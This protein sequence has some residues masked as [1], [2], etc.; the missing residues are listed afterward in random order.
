MN[1][2]IK[3]LFENINGGD[4]VD[5]AAEAEEVAQALY[6]ACKVALHRGDDYTAE[7]VVRAAVLKA[8]GKEHCVEDV[9]PEDAALDA[10]I[11]FLGVTFKRGKREGWKEPRAM[12]PWGTKTREGLRACLRRIL[13]Q[14]Q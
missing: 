11:G 6:A 5:S 1:K 4:C 14:G 8:E 10:V 9:W 3:E 7:K 2:R 13:V 12:T